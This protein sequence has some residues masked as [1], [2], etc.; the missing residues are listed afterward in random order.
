M[1]HRAYL[2]LGANI[3]DKEDT[4]RRAVQMLQAGGCRLVCASSLYLTKPVGYTDQPD[5][6]NAVISVQT[7]LTPRQ[8]LQLSQATEQSLG[9]LRTIH[10]GPRVIDIDIL[11]YEGVKIDEPDLILPH[12]LMLQRAFVMAP[13]AEIAPELHVSERLTASEAVKLI[14]ADGV[15]QIRDSGWAQTDRNS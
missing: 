15:V 4:M 13:L 3:G 6:F 2:A 11:I 10:W 8:L 5:F 7:D 9:R 12:P 14:P 1:K